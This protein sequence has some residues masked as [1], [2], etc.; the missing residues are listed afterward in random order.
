MK[1]LDIVN[2]MRKQMMFEV[3]LK[4]LFSKHERFLIANNR[5]FVIG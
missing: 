2:F 3:V 1:E 4:T 5:M